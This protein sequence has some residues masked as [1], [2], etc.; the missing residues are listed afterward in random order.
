[1]RSSSESGV[2]GDEGDQHLEKGVGGRGL[3]SCL[4]YGRSNDRCSPSPRST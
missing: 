4:P 2:L 1:M 3:F